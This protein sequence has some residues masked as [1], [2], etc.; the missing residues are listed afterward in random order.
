MFVERLTQAVELQVKNEGAQEH[1]LEEMALTNANEQCKAA[2]LS[3]PMDPAPALDDMLHVCTQKVPFMTAHLNHSSRDDSD[4]RKELPQQMP[5]HH[6]KEE[7]RV[8]CGIRLDIGHLN[9]L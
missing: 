7:Q 5:C 6:P 9:A 1:V 3:L 8:S 2:I 4:H